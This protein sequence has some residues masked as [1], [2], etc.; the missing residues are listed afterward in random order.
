MVKRLYLPTRVGVYNTDGFAALSFTS[1]HVSASSSFVMNMK[2]DSA[3]AWGAALKRDTTVA[4]Q[5]KIALKLTL[6][7]FFV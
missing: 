3:A 6:A 1:C 5:H 2:T 4:I 7:I